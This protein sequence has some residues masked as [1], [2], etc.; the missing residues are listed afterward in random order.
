MLYDFPCYLDNVKM[1]VSSTI[2]LSTI[3]RHFHMH[4]SM[5]SERLGFDNQRVQTRLRY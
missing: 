3:H 1:L 2:H 4:V 5:S